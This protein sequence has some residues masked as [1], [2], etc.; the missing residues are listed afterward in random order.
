MRRMPLSECLGYLRDIPHVAKWANANDA[1][2]ALIKDRLAFDPRTGTVY[3]KNA[4][5]ER[6][7]N[8]SDYNPQAYLTP[9]ECAAD[10]M[11]GIVANAASRLSRGYSA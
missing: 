2:C 4:W 8:P 10:H 7:S 3:R 1:I 9:R 11:A 5:V 6:Y